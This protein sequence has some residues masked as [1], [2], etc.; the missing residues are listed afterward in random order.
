MSIKKTYILFVVYALW[1]FLCSKSVYGSPGAVYV[2]FSALFFFFLLLFIKTRKKRTDI[3]SKIWMPYILYTAIG[4]LSYGMMESVIY[5]TIMLIILVLGASKNIS[6]NFPYKVFLISG[7]ISVSGIAFQILFPSL[8]SAYMDGMFIET[9]ELESWAESERGYAGFT[10]QLAATAIPIIYALPVILY[11][12]C[13]MFWI[14]RKKRFKQLLVLILIVGVFL[15][16]KRT[17][18]ICALLL[19][20]VVAFLSSKMSA[21]KLIIVL[22]GM[23]LIAIAV[24]YFVSHAADFQSSFILHRFATSIIDS[25]HGEDIT[26]GRSELY[27]LAFKAFSDYPLTGVGV[28]QF[29]EYTNAYTAVHNSYLQ[30]LCEQGI[31]GFI[32]FVF[33]LVYC[34]IKTSI[35]V[36]RTGDGNLKF[37]LFIQ[38]IFVLYAMSGNVVT[39]IDTYGIY[40]ISLGLLQQ[41]LQSISFYENNAYHT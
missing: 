35:L 9:D 36:K 2:A 27:L 3:V 1:G 4:Y 33:P 32:L 14:L 12:R 7:I 11:S 6:N 31:I 21:K 19:P 13:N 25:Q 18:A 26:S 10:Y 15:T 5:W 28:G 16:G 29:I 34:L 41:S 37:S 20:F 39:G 24:D 23:F 8:Y 17:L 30:V 40:F 38:L 22:G